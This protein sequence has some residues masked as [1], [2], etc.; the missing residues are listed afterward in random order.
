VR[1]TSL[2]AVEFACRGAIAQWSQFSY[3]ITVMN[4]S[5]FSV[6]GI[7]SLKHIGQCTYDRKMPW[8]F[9]AQTDCE[10]FCQHSFR[11][12]ARQNRYIKV[13]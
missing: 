11:D 5:N 9:K 8:E 7:D 1:E 2:I 13:T 12:A 10:Y 4:V 6:H 3:A